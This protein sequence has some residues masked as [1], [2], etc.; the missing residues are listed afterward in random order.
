MSI[1]FS[2]PLSS[3]KVPIWKF[4]LGKQRHY[5]ARGNSFWMSSGNPPLAEIPLGQA[6]ANRRSWKFLLDKERQTA[7]RGNSFWTRNGKPPLVEIPFG[8]AAAIRRSRKFLL[9]E[10]RHCAVRR[11]SSWVGNKFSFE[12]CLRL[13]EAKNLRPLPAFCKNHIRTR[14]FISKRI[15]LFTETFPAPNGYV[16]V[17]IMETFP[18]RGGNV[19]G[20]QWKRFKIRGKTSDGIS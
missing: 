14:S 9:D 7:A 19:S 15:Q 8:R 16:S 2:L 12:A 3:A 17:I 1:T 18:L 11:N 10:Q 20:I 5:A 13:G 4:P 6:T